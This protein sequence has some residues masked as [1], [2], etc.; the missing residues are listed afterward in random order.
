MLRICIS[1]VFFISGSN[2]NKSSN[3]QYNS[4]KKKS[5][6]ANLLDRIWSTHLTYSRQEQ[7]K[8]IKFAII[9]TYSRPSSKIGICKPITT[10]QS[11]PFIV[12]FSWHFKDGALN[13]AYEVPPKEAILR[14][15]CELQTGGWIWLGSIFSLPLQVKNEERLTTAT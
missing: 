15:H 13:N 11:K 14:T 3:F 7:R 8:P 1:N 4:W 2:T 9:L 6:C 12:A 5:Y 10:C